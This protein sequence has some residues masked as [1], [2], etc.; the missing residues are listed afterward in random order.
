MSKGAT[1]E[2]KNQPVRCYHCGRFVWENI[3]NGHS[4]MLEFKVQRL[5]FRCKEFG[6]KLIK[7]N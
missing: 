2:K 3:K 5:S 6:Q 4:R 1:E 7:T